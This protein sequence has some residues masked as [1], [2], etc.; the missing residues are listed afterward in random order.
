MLKMINVDAGKDPV[1]IGSANK[2]AMATTGTDTVRGQSMTG[3]QHVPEKIAVTVAIEENT[4]SSAA[5]T[6]AKSAKEAN[7]A[8]GDQEDKVSLGGGTD[9]CRAQPTNNLTG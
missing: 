6:K 8:I 7:V 4:A 5:A 1:V 9:D 3:N 2:S